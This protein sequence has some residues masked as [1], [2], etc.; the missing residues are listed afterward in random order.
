MEAFMWNSEFG[1]CFPYAVAGTFIDLL[2]GGK[3]GKNRLFRNV[4]KQLRTIT[5][6]KPLSFV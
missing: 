2:S 3:D 4:G 1:H 6:H 5:S